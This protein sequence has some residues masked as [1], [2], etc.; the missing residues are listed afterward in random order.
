[1]GRITTHV[2]DV[3]SGKPAAGVVVELHVRGA[4]PRMV[5][6]TATNAD[7]RCD[8][9][10]LQGSALRAGEYEL[11]FAMGDYFDKQGLALPRPKFLDQVVLRFGVSDAT[12]HYHV[13]LLVSPW[14]FSTY[15]G[16]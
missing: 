3:A 4:E 11:I 15:R 2:L 6:S 14:S 13:P 7:G 16:S 8:Q 1:M 9:P 12:Q 10:L 5:H